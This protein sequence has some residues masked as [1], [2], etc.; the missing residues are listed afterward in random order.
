MAISSAASLWDSP[1][2]DTV[3]QPAKAMN[4]SRPLILVA[5]S[6]FA[7]YEFGQ[8]FRSRSRLL[9]KRLRGQ[10]RVGGE[11]LGARH[12]DHLGPP[13]DRFP[14]EDGLPH[15]LFLLLSSKTV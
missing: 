8:A 5:P 10:L 15:V 1:P 9:E 2:D 6:L 12:R 14:F 13:L 3:P 7:E 11:P 4:A